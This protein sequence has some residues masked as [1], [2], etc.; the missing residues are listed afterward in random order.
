MLGGNGGFERNGGGG[1]PPDETVS[2]AAS[3][4]RCRTGGGGGPPVRGP[5]CSFEATRKGCAGVS[6]SAL[7]GSTGDVDGLG[8]GGENDGRGGA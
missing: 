1:G 7:E 8:R 6:R 2:G 4:G 5:G 3:L